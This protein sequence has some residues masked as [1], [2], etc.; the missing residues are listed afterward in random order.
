MLELKPEMMQNPSFWQPH[1]EDVLVRVGTKGER[2]HVDLMD[3]NKVILLFDR[4]ACYTSTWMCILLDG[5]SPI[6]SHCMLVHMFFLGAI[7]K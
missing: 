1:V 6:I 5:V 3:L 7:L 4:D 2:Q